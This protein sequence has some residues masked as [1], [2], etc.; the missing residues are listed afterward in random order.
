MSALYK[1]TARKYL[2]GKWKSLKASHISGC[3]RRDRKT[4]QKATQKNQQRTQGFKFINDPL[5]SALSK[6]L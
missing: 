4:S 5:P 2:P 3:R 1:G 6:N